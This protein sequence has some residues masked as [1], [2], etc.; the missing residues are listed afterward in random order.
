MSLIAPAARSAGSFVPRWLAP[1]QLVAPFARLRR[2]DEVVRP[3]EGLPD[4]LGRI[5]D[6]EIRLARTRADI[7]RAQ[8][9]RY[10][11]FFEE[12][13][14]KASARA[15]LSRRDVDAF[16]RVC[17]HLLVID[18]GFRRGVGGK[19]FPRV[20]GCYRVLRQ[21]VAE[22]AE[23]FYSA[24]EFDLRGLFAA[25]PGARCLELGRACVLAP[26]RDRK[27]I[28][29]LWHGLWRYVRHHE[30]DLMFGCGSLEGVDPALSAQCL[31]YLRHHAAAPSDWG[32]RALPA[33][34]LPMERVAREALD[35][36]AAFQSLPP[37][38]KAYLRLGARCGDGAVLDRPFGVIDVLVVM[39]V[40]EISARHTRFYE[41]KALARSA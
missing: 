40:C 18:R 11:V 32:L 26:Y 6:L 10:K 7:R 38:L 28:D 8:K 12:K 25:H 3:P 4:L 5:G 36:K 20:V 14:A 19:V 17:D 29:L 15:M 37:L 31:S 24:R 22:R 2:R 35:A 9:L 41:A 30:I 21:D 23:G 33:R 1:A 16:D 27:T 13:G 39:K 34:Y